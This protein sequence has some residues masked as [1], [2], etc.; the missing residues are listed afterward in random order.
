MRTTVLLAWSDR[1]VHPSSWSCNMGRANLRRDH[2]L[3]S[4]WTTVMNSSL[5]LWSWCSVLQNDCIEHGYLVI[6]CVHEI[7][8]KR[9]IIWQ[10]VKCTCRLISSPAYDQRK[11]EQ[12]SLPPPP[13]WMAAFYHMYS[14][15]TDYL[16]FDSSYPYSDSEICP[17]WPLNYQS[18]HR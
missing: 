15:F 11:Q 16:C 14:A 1:V 12:V 17:S 3:E 6:D 13:G 4:V 9:N 10:I 8:Q 18:A 7:V 2:L 5:S